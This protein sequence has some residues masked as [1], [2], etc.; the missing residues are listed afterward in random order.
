MPN[1]HPFQVISRAAFSC[2]WAALVRAPLV[3]IGRGLLPSLAMEPAI[4]L[5]WPPHALRGVI[6]PHCCVLVSAF[7]GHSARWA[8]SR[9]ERWPLAAP[10]DCHWSLLVFGVQW[11]RDGLMPHRSQVLLAGRHLSLL[12][13]YKTYQPLAVLPDIPA[14]RRLWSALCRACSP[15]TDHA[16]VQ[17]GPHRLP[18]PSNTINALGC[19]WHPTFGLLFRPDPY[20]QWSLCNNRLAVVVLCS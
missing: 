1:T 13:C 9:P 14:F 15:L 6:L 5:D 4:V 3:L 16:S 11:T 2:L 19:L 17:A 8:F 7:L 10:T 20:L 18:L 12:L